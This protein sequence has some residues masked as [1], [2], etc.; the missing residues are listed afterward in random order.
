MN[1]AKHTVEQFTVTQEHGGPR[2]VVDSDGN[3]RSPFDL[4]ESQQQRITDLE[5]QLADIEKAWLDAEVI[6][7]RLE[8]QLAEAQGREK[9]LVEAIKKYLDG[10]YV[11]PRT[12]RPN[13]CEHGTYYWEDCGQ[14]I[15]K[16]FQPVL[17]KALAAEV[18]K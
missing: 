8:R 14:C 1:D 12:N 3:T 2:F 18:S 5:R 9:E 11:H 4:I 13:N 6:G 7:V 10:D 16:H 17:D 15:D